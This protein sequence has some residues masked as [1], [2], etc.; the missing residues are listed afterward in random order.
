MEFDVIVVGAGAVGGSIAY[1]LSSR[2]LK[3]CRVGETDRA[4]AAS[5]AAGAMNGCFGEVTSGLLASDFGRLKLDMDRQAQQLWPSWAERLA[6]SSGNT[7]SLFTAMGTHVLLNTAGMDEVDSVN[8]DTI[9]STLTEYGEPFEVIDPRKMEWLKPNHLVRPLRGLYIP[10]EHSVNSHLLLEKLD[11]AFVAEGGTLKN[12]NAERVLAEGG[13]VTGVELGSGEVLWARKVIVAAGVHSLDLLS[14]FDEVVKR[15]PPLF[16]GYGVSILVKM[17]EGGDLPNS[18]IRT[19]NR[20]F[21]CGLHCVPRGD[22]ILYL[23]ATNI[24]SEQPKKHALISDVQFLLDCA[25]DQLS[26]DLHGAEVISIQVG[27]RPIPADG[28]PLI[29]ECGIEGLWLATGTYRDGL[30]QSPL[31]AGYIADCLTGMKSNSLDLSPFTPVRAPLA[32]FARENTVKETVQ[33]MFA[34]GYEYRWDIKPYWF[35][36]LDEGLSRNYQKLIDDLHPSFTPPPELVAFSYLYES[37]LNKLSQYYRE[38]T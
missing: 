21:A 35:P 26:L 32:G 11:A 27:N 1:E 28:F 38:W 12:E 5:R 18:V 8:Y 9:E 17:P 36:L 30:H 20:A 37:I 31:L 7:T 24:I 23:G 13:V 4:N 3:V 14:H 29:G 2:G 16:S 15:I 25:V 22:G 19:P 6:V 10:N 34:T 33:Q